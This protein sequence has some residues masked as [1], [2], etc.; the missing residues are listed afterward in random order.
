MVVQAAPRPMAWGMRPSADFF[1]AGVPECVVHRR[2]GR[3]GDGS[4]SGIMDGH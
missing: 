2:A 4:H 1:K 3:G